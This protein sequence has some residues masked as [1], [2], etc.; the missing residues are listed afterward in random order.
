VKIT[1]TVDRE[2]CHPTRDLKLYQGL[3]FKDAG[4]RKYHFC[5]HCG[6]FWTWNRAAGEMDGG[7]E[8]VMVLT[9]EP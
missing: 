9:S 1:E 2:C 3:R 6:Q 5:V 8:K 7:L 4:N